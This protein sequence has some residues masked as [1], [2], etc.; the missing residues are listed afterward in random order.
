[1]RRP[2]FEAYRPICPACAVNGAASPL[3]LA[4]IWHETADEIIAGTLACA[5]CETRFPIIEAIP[6]LVPE[7]RRFIAEQLAY[8][9]LRDDMPGPLADWLGDAAGPGSWYDTMRQH[10]SGYGF[11][12]WS[13]DAH[14]S[15]LAVL[16]AGLMRLPQRK[17]GLALDLG[18][19]P[20]RTSVALVEE[21][22]ALA[23]GLDLN[24]ALLRLARQALAGRV[25]FP[26]RRSGLTYELHEVATTID[27]ATAA[28]VDFWIADAT[29][30][31][32]AG[33]TIDLITGLNV[34]DCMAAPIAGIAAIGRLLRPGGQAVLATP[35]DWS[36]AAT[37]LEHWLGGRAGSPAAGDGAASLRAVIAADPHLQL[38]A[39]EADLPW[40]VRLHDRAEMQYRAHLA[41]L[42][43]DG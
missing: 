23:L 6:V 14:S 11:D 1:V 13:G 30:P 19:G 17:D 34:L 35:Y 28:R 42:G 36:P 9:T 43:R 31:P 22:A 4:E 5:G 27:A 26:L 12:H 16:R 29:A 10:Q 38:L 7:P 18:C 39:E 24:V 40:R 32:F 21:G 8:F 15:A 20:G 3:A 2:H 41:V 37:P 25:R 33:A